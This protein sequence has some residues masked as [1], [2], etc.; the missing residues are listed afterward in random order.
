MGWRLLEEPKGSL[1]AD[2][3]AIRT[4]PFCDGGILV[5]PTL[6]TTTSSASSFG[7][8]TSR[9]GER[10]PSLSLDV[11][12]GGVGGKIKLPTSIINFKMFY[13]NSFNYRAAFI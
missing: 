12:D 3:L 4:R 9:M 11:D 8:T 2:T 6:T 13:N 10:L 5:R 1:A 7:E